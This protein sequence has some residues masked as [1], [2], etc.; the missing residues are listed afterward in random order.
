[1]AVSY[2]KLWKRLIDKSIK[3]KG[4]CAASFSPASITKMDRNSHVTTEIF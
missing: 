4:L 2:K 1:M 3:K